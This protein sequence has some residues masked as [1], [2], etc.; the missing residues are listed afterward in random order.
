MKN[1]KLMSGPLKG[2][3]NV[4][5]LVLV[6]LMFFAFKAEAQNNGLNFNGYNNTNPD[7]V[8]NKVTC[9]N[10]IGNFG[11]SDFTIEFYIKTTA[12]DNNAQF[13]IA[14]R[15]VCGHASF[16][17]VGITNGVVYFEIDQ[18]NNGTNIN[19][20]TSTT[21]VNDG[22]WHHVALVRSGTSLTFYIDGV[23]S[24]SETNSFITNVNNS[25]NLTIGGFGSNCTTNQNFV[26][27]LDE[28]RIWS[29]ARTQSQ[30]QN[31]IN[32]ELT[33]TETGLIT[34]YT[35][36]QGTANANN[37]GVTTLNDLTSNQ[38][39]G[40]LSNF[41]LS[42]TTSN[43]VSVIKTTVAGTVS[44]NQTITSPAGTGVTTVSGD[45]SLN[46][47]DWIPVSPPMSWG[48]EPWEQM[49]G[50][51]AAQSFKASIS[52][53]WSGL[54]I[55]VK[56]IN[57]QGDFTLQIYSGDGVY[58]STLLTQ[59]VSIYNNGINNFTFS[60]PIA[61]I[62]GQFY[63]F[64]LSS[65]GY[66]DIY[67]DGSGSSLPFGTNYQNGQGYGGA[68]YFENTYQINNVNWNNLTLTG[69]NGD[70]L[71]WQRS[72]DVGFS[73]P[74]TIASTSTTLYSN[75][76]GNLSATTYFRAVVKY[77]GSPAAYTNTV[78]ISAS[79]NTRSTTQV[80]TSQCGTTLATLSTDILANNVV[81]ATEYRFK[82]VAYGATNV[83]E[84]GS[85]R[86]FNLTML[87]SGAVYNTAYT[88]SVAVK[89][90]NA[91]GGY[92]AECVVTTP[93]LPTTQVRAAQCNAILASNGTDILADN[94]QFATAYRFRVVVNGT[95]YEINPIGKRRYFKLLQ[96][97][98][99][100]TA[101]TTY[102]ISVAAQ[103]NG[104]WGAINYGSECY[105]TTPGTADN[106]RQATSIATNDFSAVAYPNPSNSAFNLQINGSNNE[107][108]SVLVFDTIGRQIENKVVN[109]SAIE[110][111]TIGQ[112]YSAGIYNV[113]V[114]QG[115]N[116]K[117]VRLVKN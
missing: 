2:T 19:D 54:K 10:V 78:T 21:A 40:T 28:L 97:P 82:V 1:N 36:N 13:L 20:L 37:T 9:G 77:G 107:N 104:A 63:T 98:I 108:V 16:F 83:I 64:Q 56:N 86:Y 14:K 102:I 52:A 91:W 92:G 117:T 3:K 101:G 113:I 62:A 30:I 85:R 45:K 66:A 105:V 8:Q 35:F 6:F 55:N 51:A 50:Y 60:S 100:V 17:N 12:A 57:Q 87:P 71:Y 44:A 43:W 27:S 15:S 103:F 5:R 49:P 80:Q 61:L 95:T 93:A 33:G 41:A 79:T 42:G 94:L 59:T 4:A 114:S 58:G 53:S 32:N 109:A 115:M 76:I 46:S 70:V 39:N 31:N 84:R 112:N 68:L 22:T 90:N 111:T 110:N 25:D 89:K 69:N 75:S 29:L 72:S 23:A 7:G 48:P 74:T 34:Y 47:G 96:L 24:G 11:T 26:G 38:N 73:N 116:T 67:I 88:I 106:S 81:G 99:P 65:N 18:D